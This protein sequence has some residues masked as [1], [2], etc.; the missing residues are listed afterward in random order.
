MRQFAY[1]ISDH[2]WVCND[3]MFIQV[4]KGLKGFFQEG[5]TDPRI[6]TSEQG[7]VRTCLDLNFDK[8]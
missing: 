1:H 2:Q 6:G 8:H 4:S 3:M 5:G 7:K